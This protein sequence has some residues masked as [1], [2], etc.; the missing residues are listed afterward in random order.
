MP[1]LVNT[2]E[3]KNTLEN[4]IALFLIK[5]TEE[6]GV[7]FDELQSVLNDCNSSITERII[8]MNVPD[9]VK[10]DVRN[11]IVMLFFRAALQRTEE[12]F[13]MIAKEKGVPLE[14]LLNEQLTNMDN[15]LFRKMNKP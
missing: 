8:K 3:I 7:G 6:D 9:N 2:T 15:T 11:M 1:K 4:N 13:R 10:E 12:I 14:T 5:L